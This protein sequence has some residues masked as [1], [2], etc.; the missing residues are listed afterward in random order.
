[1]LGNAVKVGLG[2][3]RFGEGCAVRSGM[4]V[5]VAHVTDCQG[6]SLRGRAVEAR[7]GATRYVLLRWCAAWQSRRGM[8]M[9]CL[10][11]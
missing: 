3:A 11:G 1:M 7:S 4:A 6:K 10:L 5:K 9:H 8:V 2:A